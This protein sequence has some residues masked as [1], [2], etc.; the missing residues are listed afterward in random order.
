MLL[1]CAFQSMDPPQQACL[2]GDDLEI[3]LLLLRGPPY[4]TSSKFTDFFTPPLLVTV[5]NQQIL[6]LSSVFWGPPPPTKCG[7]HTYGSPLML[8]QTMYDYSL[9]PFSTFF[10]LFC[11]LLLRP[12]PRLNGGICFVLR[13]VKLLSLLEFERIGG[14]FVT[15]GLVICFGAEFFKNTYWRYWIK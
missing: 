12:S 9:K 3:S 1:K 13:L 2:G 11:S 8:K 6:F 7:R 15:C 5:T 4:K 10:Y 14:K